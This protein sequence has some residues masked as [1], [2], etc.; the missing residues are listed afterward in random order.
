MSSSEEQLEA[1]KV[2]FAKADADR[3]VKQARIEDL[4][5]AI[6]EGP[7]SAKRLSDL[8]TANT[9]YRNALAGIAA[10]ETASDSV[11]VRVQAALDL[12]AYVQTDE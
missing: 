11:K 7:E 5:K 9:F 6:A 2:E 3:L 1:L 12:K 10:D 8:D 4:E